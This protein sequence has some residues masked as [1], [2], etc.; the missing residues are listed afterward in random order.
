MTEP[1]ACPTSQRDSLAETLGVSRGIPSQ[2]NS[3][4]IVKDLRSHSASR[5][6]ETTWAA[7][8]SQALFSTRSF[9]VAPFRASDAAVSGVVRVGETTDAVSPRQ[10]LFSTFSTYFLG[11]AQRGNQFVFLRGRRSIEMQRTWSSPQHSIYS[12][13]LFLSS[14]PDH[15]IQIKLLKSRLKQPPESLP[16]P[17]GTRCVKKGRALIRPKTADLL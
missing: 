10:A 12:K 6:G 1:S 2:F 14:P 8:P 17:Y 7:S 5:G 16:S 11:R 13:N 9:K 4:S 3:Y 15:T